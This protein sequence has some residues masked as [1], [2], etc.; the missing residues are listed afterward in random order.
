MSR[1]DEAKTYGYM[2]AETVKIEN[3]EIASD[4][5]TEVAKLTVTSVE[6]GYT[7]QDTFGRYIYMKGDYNSFNISTDAQES[8][9]WNIT[10][11]GDNT[12]SV[13]NPDK[14]KTIMYDTQYSSYGCYPSK[15]DARQYVS[16][17]KYVSK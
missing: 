5:I 15:T 11:N 6:G 3:G 10:S 4:A 14:G 9:I 17:Y 1:L 16:I 8:Y 7:L 12:F 13:T 2:P